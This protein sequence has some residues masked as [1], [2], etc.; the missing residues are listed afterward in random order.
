MKSE[1]LLSM[2]SRQY[3][4]MNKVYRYRMKKV[5]DMSASEVISVCHFY[6]EEN[7]QTRD[8]K[9][10]REKIESEFRFCPALQE[11][12]DEGLCIDIQMIS[13]GYI[14]KSALPDY[15]IDFS[16]TESKCE[17]CRYLL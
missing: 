13:S 14:K 11:Y 10:Y 15:D 4:Q 6:C 1:I 9:A 5:D 2:I 12:I 8:F 7:N 17:E 16:K 3:L